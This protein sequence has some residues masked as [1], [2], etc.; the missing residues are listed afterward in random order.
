MTVDQLAGLAILCGLLALGL[1]AAGLFLLLTGH[2][3]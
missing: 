3:S 2:W 1:S